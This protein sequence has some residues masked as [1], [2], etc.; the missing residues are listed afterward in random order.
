MKTII[1]NIKT[2]QR[3]ARQKRNKIKDRTTR[4]WSYY[5]GLA[6]G[7]TIALHQIKEAQQ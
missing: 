2:A 4:E 1:A 6:C 7:F 3:V 5:H